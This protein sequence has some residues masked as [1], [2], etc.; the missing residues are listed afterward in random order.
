MCEAGKQ[1]ADNKTIKNINPERINLVE[2]YQ[3]AINDILIYFYIKFCLLKKGKN[4]TRK[5]VV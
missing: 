1:A 3:E 5:K 4:K 2:D